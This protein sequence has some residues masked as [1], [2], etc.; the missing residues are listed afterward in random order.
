LTEPIFATP[1]LANLQ[2]ELSKLQ[3]FAMTRTLAP[4][5]LANLPLETAS[6]LLLLLMT[7]MHAQLIGV[8]NPTEKST[9][10]LSFATTRTHALM[11]LA[12]ESRDASSPML[13]LS[14]VMTTMLALLMDVHPT[15]RL[16]ST[17][18]LFVMTRTHAPK[19]LAMLSRDAS[20]LHWVLLT[21]MTTTLAPLMF[22]I[23]KT[24]S[25]T[26]QSFVMTTMHALT[27]HAT[28]KLDAS[29]LERFVMTRTCAPLTNAL[30]E[31]VSTLQFLALL[32][33]AR[34]S[35]AALKPENASTLMSA[36]TTT[37]H[38]PSILAT[39]TLENVSTLSEIALM[40]ANAPKILVMLSRD[41]STLLLTAMTTTHALMILALL[42]V[43]VSAPT[44]L[45]M[46][47]M[48][49]PEILATQTLEQSFTKWSL[50]MTRTLALMIL[51]MSRLDANMFQRTSMHSMQ[52]TQTNARLFSAMFWEEFSPKMST[53]MTVMHA[54]PIL[55]TMQLDLASMTPFLALMTMLALLTLAM[56]RLD[57]KTHQRI[58]MTT[59]TAPLILA[60][61]SRDASTLQL[62]AMTTTCALKIHAL[63][64]NASTLQ[65]QSLNQLTNAQLQLAE[66]LKD[67]TP[68]RRIVTTTMH[69]PS[70]LATAQLESARTKERIAM[71][72][73]NAPLT[74]AL[75]ETASTLQ[76]LALTTILA[77]L[78]LAMQQLDASTHQ[79]LTTRL[80]KAKTDATNTLAILSLEIK[81]RLQFFATTPML[82]LMT[83][84]TQLQDVSSLQRFAK[85]R[86]CASHLIATQS[87][88]SALST[89]S[90]AMTTTNAQL[91]LAMERPENAS[92]LQSAAVMETNAQPILVNPTLDFA[93]TFPKSAMTKTLAPEMLATPLLETASSKTFLLNWLL[94][95]LQTFASRPLA[96]QQRESF[97]LLSFVLQLL[98]APPLLVIQTE[99]ASTPQLFANLKDVLPPINATQL[100]TNANLS[101]QT[102]TMEMHALLTHSL[103]T[104]D[105]NTLQNALLLMLA[106]SPLAATELALTFQRTAM[107]EMSAPSTLAISLLEL[108]ST[109]QSLAHV[110][111]TTLEL[112]ILTLLNV[113]SERLAPTTPNVTTT[114]HQPMMSALQ[115]S[116]AKTLTLLELIWTDIEQKTNFW[117]LPE[118]SIK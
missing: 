60:T 98:L 31:T 67:H 81:S 87:L 27:S 38:A 49:A 55:A 39:S 94:L 23:N 4:R 110:V 11:T 100:P 103:N 1:S 41:A 99:D 113:S 42:T 79:S 50:V 40:Q 77:P 58:A 104:L 65:F 34:P 64:E 5:T 78:I 21:L 8:A 29:T 26:F 19:I 51:A 14:T 62:F 47:T 109:P 83:L 36:V 112:A 52:Q 6:T 80:L 91:T 101:F 89:K 82:A 37:M 69:A 18:L 32:F 54:P 48:L 71:T 53:V 118:K 33:H 76:S 96:M 74:L 72:T 88:E 30:M 92:T 17:L 105:V 3:L 35:S 102:V 59:T 25:N 61:R 45:L 9:T 46:T 116:D 84:A 70:T 75:M 57:A 24:E 10:T 97:K 108:A 56:Q 117:F 43:D 115:L 7:T 63:L 44:R 15:K 95:L 85:E 16:A 114:I 111:K 107:M 22:A 20:T 28:Q 93:L 90:L 106:P 68:T 86:I 13:E 73:T 2:P 66:L 12:T